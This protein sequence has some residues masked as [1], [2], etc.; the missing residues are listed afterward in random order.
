VSNPFKCNNSIENTKMW[1]ETSW[2]RT[3]T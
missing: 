1:S 2:A 3:Q